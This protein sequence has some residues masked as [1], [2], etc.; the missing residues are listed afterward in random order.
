MRQDTNIGFKI[1]DKD[2]EAVKSIVHAAIEQKRPLE[3][4][5][6]FSEPKALALLDDLF[7]N[8]D[9]LL[10]AHLDH[11]RVNVFSVQKNEKLLREQIE[12][13]LEWGGDYA[14]NHISHF[15]MTVRLERHGD[16]M[17]RLKTNLDFVNAICREYRFPIHIENTFHGLE[18][19]KAIFQA[20]IDNDWEY[21]HCCFD[22]GHA[23]VWSTSTLSEW[24]AFLRQLARQGIRH[25]FHLH[26]N[27]GLMDEHL[28]LTEAER[29]GFTEPDCFTEQWDY[30][31]SLRRIAREFFEERKIFEVPMEEAQENLEYALSRLGSA[32]AQR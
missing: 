6:Y 29:R 3:V 15:P 18:F 1:V 17:D 20:I 9:I 2:L 31:E 4:G 13:V 24:L 26:A 32:E 27:S 19:Y 23:K 30:F 25:H 21:L 16:M 10:N 14:V 8:N 11:R 22:I 5:L 28:S 12:T 7:G